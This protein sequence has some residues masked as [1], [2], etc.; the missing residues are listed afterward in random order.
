MEDCSRA[1]EPS[2]ATSTAYA[3]SR[4]PFASTAAAAGSSSTTRILISLRHRQALLDLL[5]DLADIPGGLLFV[6]LRRPECITPLA[7]GQAREK[8]ARPADVSGSDSVD[9]VAV[10]HAVVE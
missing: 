3:C 4:S 7:L 9:D 8:F 2:A 10:D 5:F 6:I 1:M